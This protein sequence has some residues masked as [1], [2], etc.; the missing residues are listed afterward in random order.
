MQSI[1]PFAPLTGYTVTGI[2]TSTTPAVVCLEL[3]EHPN[4]C[5]HCR[6]PLLQK[7]GRRPQQIADVPPAPAKPVKLAITTQRYLCLACRKTFYEPLPELAT[8]H[9]MTNRLYVWIGPEAE[10]RQFTT[11][12]KEVGIAETTVR[13]VFQEYLDHRKETPRK[14]QAVTTLTLANVSVIRPACAIADGDRGDLLDV[15]PNRGQAT[16]ID[17]LV[18]ISRQGA[19][20]NVCIE[21]IDLQRDAVRSALPAARL[22]IEPNAIQNITTA[23]MSKVFDQAI[24]RV[25]AEVRATVPLD[26]KVLM[27]AAGELTDVE[28]EALYEWSR[29]YPI[30]SDAYK[31]REHLADVL[32]QLTRSHKLDYTHWW[33]TVPAP[34]RSPFKPLH[35]FFADW[36]AELEAGADY[37]LVPPSDVASSTES[38]FA[39]LGR[40]YSF[41]VVRELLLISDT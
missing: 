32:R 41:R 11:I 17:A 16:L 9:A 36:T 40:H 19:I 5:V 29:R 21:P 26:Q 8:N 34:I 27:K 18:G 12:A 39:A 38:R 23:V 10:K 30:I 24:E 37:S 31:A 33:Q 25:P 15:L 6:S 1:I 14:R 3:L 28:E 7:F 35:Q 13:K 20:S 4:Q 22:A 2:D